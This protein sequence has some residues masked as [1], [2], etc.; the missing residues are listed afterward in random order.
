MMACFFTGGFSSSPSAFTCSA[1]AASTSLIL[2]SDC[3]G[4]DALSGSGIVRG[5]LGRPG[6]SAG[7]T[8][9]GYLT[10]AALGRARS[11]VFALGF[12]MEVDADADE[13]GEIGVSGDMGGDA[14][15]RSTGA[16]VSADDEGSGAGAGA[17][18][19]RGRPRPLFGVGMSGVGGRREAIGGD[20]DR[21][22]SGLPSRVRADDVE[23]GETGDIGVSGEDAVGG[24]RG[25]ASGSVTAPESV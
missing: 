2:K 13:A 18:R 22:R 6:G 9:N 15:L 7:S 5:V 24:G 25:T 4:F 14:A 23:K 21:S 8:G 3:P 16:R 19:L 10:P 11:S 17:G 20:G 1:R 12:G